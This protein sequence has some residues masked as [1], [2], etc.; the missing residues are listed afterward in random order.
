MRFLLFTGFSFYTLKNW[1]RITAFLSSASYFQTFNHTPNRQQTSSPTYEMSNTGIA[2]D[3]TGGNISNSAPGFDN[4]GGAQ[5]RAN[6]DYGSGGPSAGLGDNVEKDFGEREQKG[7]VKGVLN[8][9]TDKM[10]PSHTD[11]VQQQVSY[12][13]F[14]ALQRARLW[15]EGNDANANIDSC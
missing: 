9:I 5:D 6:A 2:N 12:I 15:K 1:I 7:G 10:N 4:S 14:L 13:Y 8:K 11:P 3:S